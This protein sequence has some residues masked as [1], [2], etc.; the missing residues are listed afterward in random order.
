MVIAAAVVVEEHD[1]AVAVENNDASTENGKKETGMLRKALVKPIM[2]TIEDNFGLD[3][4]ARKVAGKPCDVINGYSLSNKTVVQVVPAPKKK[5]KKNKGA[6]G[7]SA[8]AAPVAAVKEVESVTVEV[9][10]PVQSPLEKKIASFR[11]LTAKSFDVEGKFVFQ[12]IFSHDNTAVSSGERPIKMEVC[13]GAGE[14]AVTQVSLF[15]MY[16]FTVEC[17]H[18]YKNMLLK[19]LLLNCRLRMIPHQTGLLWNCAVIER[20]K[21]S[22][23]LYLLV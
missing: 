7:D 9:V 12:N 11:A 13:S 8:S 3:M 4:F 20:T 14:W 1:D 21:Y 2:K 10:P 15:F 6:K 18:L 22:P 17:T 23:K 5:N 19:L 16:T